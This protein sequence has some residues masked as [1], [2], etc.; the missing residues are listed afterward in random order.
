[1][2]LRIVAKHANY[3]AVKANDFVWDNYTMGEA[4]NS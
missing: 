3:R 4:M 2:L 1:M